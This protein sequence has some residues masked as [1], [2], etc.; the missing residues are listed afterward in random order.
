[1]RRE[2]TLVT[3]VVGCSLTFIATLLDSTSSSSESLP[4]FDSKE[5]KLPGDPAGDKGNSE[6][7]KMS[8]SL[9]DSTSD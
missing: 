4:K 3:A 1:V 6:S 8:V 9:M 7:S 5:S 2:S